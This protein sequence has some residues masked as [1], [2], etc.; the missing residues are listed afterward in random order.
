MDLQNLTRAYVFSILPRDVNFIR[1][2]PNIATLLGSSD[3][4]LC[5]ALLTVTR[6]ISDAGL[7]V[8]QVAV[9]VSR[10]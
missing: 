1:E 3:E 7:A 8:K 9:G 2:M 4:D 6:R 5:V 10:R